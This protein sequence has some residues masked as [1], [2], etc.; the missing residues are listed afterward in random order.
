MFRTKFVYTAV[1]GGAL[2]VADNAATANELTGE[3]IREKISGKTVFLQTPFGVELPLT[4]ASNGQVTGDGRGTGL[5]KYFAPTET[6]E[7]WTAGNRMCQKFPTWYKG[8]TVCFQ[9]RSQGVRTLLWK[10]DDG[11]TGKATIG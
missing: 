2:M 3:E 10:R 11:K 1:V 4:Y 8:R 5:G 6:G 9:L 7:W